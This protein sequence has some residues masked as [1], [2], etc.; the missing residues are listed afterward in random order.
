[1]TRPVLP[2]GRLRWTALLTAAAVLA[3]TG[4]MPGT[5]RA[6]AAAAGCARPEGVYRGST[7]WP[8]QLLDLP[9]IWPLSRG[10]GQLVAV[11]GTG[12]DPANAQFAHG[13]VLPQINLIN[14]GTRA[15]CDGRGTFAAG[16]V[17]AQPDPATTFAGVAPAAKLL[18]V[19]VTEA[20]GGASQP[21]APGTVATA[22]STAV[23]QHATVILVVVPAAS[24]SPALRAA[25]RSALKTG[26]VVVSP[27]AGSQAGDVSYPT[28]LPGV[29]GVG[30]LTENGGPMQ[31]EAGDVAL[32]A[33]GAGLVSTAAGASG[34]H[35]G[36]RWGVSDP[37]FGAAFVAG[38]VALLRSYQ[39]SLTPAQILARLEV[40]ASRPPSGG[41]DPRLGWGTL[42][43]Y[44]AVASTLPASIPAPGSTVVP[45]RARRVA[46][47]TAG[48]APA[49]PDRA[50]GEIALLG[51]CLA[52][53]TAL[54]AT[55]ARRGSSRRWRAGADLPGHAGTITVT[56]AGA[57]AGST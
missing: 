7:P 22:I 9:R 36:Q 30:G 26:V 53:L 34:G 48:P 54:M 24:D 12:I 32:A 3:L 14:G 28:A 44:A 29:I 15:D 21:P 52:V 55:V 35:L 4:P 19:R 18:P 27:A 2:G 49:G 50:P 47:M 25:V 6:A 11:V 37:S 40:T 20:V 43:A 41:D 31:A 10:A 45:Q 56:R 13:Q 5:A 38:A 8:Q 1:M 39:P 42:D 46:P 23:A 51:V 17:A 16:I 57:S 33:P